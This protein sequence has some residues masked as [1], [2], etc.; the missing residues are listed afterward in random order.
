MQRV[1]LAA[2]QSGASS[3]DLVH[4]G[5]MGSHGNSSQNCHQQMMT[6]YFSKVKSPKLSYVTSIVWAR[7]PVTGEKK[8]VEKEL[9][10]LLPHHWIECLEQNGL[11]ETLTASPQELKDFWQQQDFKKNPQLLKSK[12]YW[13]S[14][15]VLEDLPIPFLLHGDHCS[16]SET[17]SLYVVSIRCLLTERS[18]KTSELLVG[19]LPK[20][21]NADTWPALWNAQARESQS[22]LQ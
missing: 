7:D 11:L 8:V 4:M 3:N 12:E 18:I 5:A 9:P 13:D 22:P 6:K 15:D 10:L 2:T 19:C 21:A 1:A 20:E 14:F 17:D 16:F